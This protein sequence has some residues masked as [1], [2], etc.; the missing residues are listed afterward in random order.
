[1]SEIDLN[2]IPLNNENENNEDINLIPPKKEKFTTMLQKSIN[3]N[4][5]FKTLLDLAKDIDFILKSENQI[6]I[7]LKNQLD[8]ATE[9]N[10]IEILQRKLDKLF[11]KPLQ[12]YVIIINELL[13]IS[14]QIGLS[15]GVSNE[16]ILYFNRKFWD[17]ISNEE[18]MGFL[19]EFA[20]K[21]G[22]IS[23][24]AQQ[25][26]VKEFIL[27][28]FLVTGIIPDFKDTNKKT[29][30]P[31]KN[32]TLTFDGGEITFANFNKN[33][34]LTYQLPFDYD[35][36]AK[37]PLFNKY[38]DRVLPDLNLQKI[39]FE[40]F[41]TMFLKDIKHEKILLLNG[42]GKNGKS[43]L[44]DVLHAL[45]GDEN[46]TSLSLASLIDPKSQT[47]ALIENK[48]LNFSS[49]IGSTKNLDLDMIKKLASQEPVEIKEVYKKPYIMKNYARLA[50]NCNSLPKEVENSEGFHRRLLI[51]PFSQI[52]SDDEID[53]NLAKKIIAS[54]L[55]G[56]FNLIIE[57]MKRFREQ[58]KFTNS[59]IIKDESEKY[60]R[61]SN[62]VLSFIDEENY[63]ISDRQDMRISAFYQAYRIYC[64]DNGFYPFNSKKFNQQLRDAGYKIDKKTGGYFYIFYDKIPLGIE[65][66]A[67]ILQIT[68][69]NII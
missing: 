43:V 54:E 41:G 25:F 9:P 8:H 26:K 22:L 53:L 68:K 60:R 3:K 33:D 63:I 30:I 11:P 52:I 31:F 1:M 50:F 57:G 55:P 66:S 13:E 61:D 17:I 2:L 59:L 15:V 16:K 6:A 21:S 29:K 24:E 58:E 67:I 35:E 44:H 32:G 39:I 27:K 19:G 4:D 47:R 65:D 36:N 23:L 5:V 7:D 12:Q 46:I 64:N 18:F 42:S 40:F 20:Q 14:E 45:L 37:C 38:L 62:S 51:I 28:Q 49:E 56:I 34:Y 48:L 10:H 69:N